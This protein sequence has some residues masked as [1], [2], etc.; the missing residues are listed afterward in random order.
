MN[1]FLILFFLGKHTVLETNHK[2]F[3]Q[4]LRIKDLNQLPPCIL[5]FHSQ[6]DRFS[7]DIDHILYVPGKE[8]YNVNALTRILSHCGIAVDT[9]ELQEL[10]DQ[11]MCST[12]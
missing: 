4:L 10:A 7:F 2:V 3:V 6:L 9:A 11:T 12:Y 8:L 5:R 1:F